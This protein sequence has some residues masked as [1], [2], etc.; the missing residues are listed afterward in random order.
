MQ[1]KVAASG[2]FK[3][4]GKEVKSNFEGLI[5]SCRLWAS[6]FVLNGLN[7]CLEIYEIFRADHIDSI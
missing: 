7:A 3:N 6:H 1:I 2:C 4:F 5:L